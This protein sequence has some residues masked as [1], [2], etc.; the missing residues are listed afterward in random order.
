MLAKDLISEL[1]PPLRPSDTGAKGLLWM[2]IFRVSHL[3]IVQQNEFLGLISDMDIFDRNMTNEP[4]GSY[5]QPVFSPFVYEHQH[6][7]EVVELASRLDL[8][9][10]P[11]LTED[12]KYLGLISS[13]QLIQ[14]FGDLAAVKAP[15]GIL[16]LELNAN[17]YSLSQIA[18]MVEEND[19]KI[20]SCY[21]TSPPDS[22]KIEVT[23]KIN[24][25]DLTS[26]IQTFLR[27]EYTVKASFQSNDQNEDILRNNYDQFMMYLNV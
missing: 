12:H 1:I 17:D 22:V 13:R 2:E 27:Y 21:V 3:P 14:A 5:Q 11:V 10:V 9:A 18:R 4:L 8:T 20:L 26:I 25:V 16:V 24:R 19:A 7:Y 23:L 6:L 15:G